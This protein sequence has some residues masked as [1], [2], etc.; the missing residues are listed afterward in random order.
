MNVQ[1]SVGNL[2]PVAG[3]TVEE[4]V[5]ERFKVRGMRQRQS[6]LLIR[7][8]AIVLHWIPYYSGRDV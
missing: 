1:R 5:R 7:K 3:K 6:A 8:V 4:I 2:E